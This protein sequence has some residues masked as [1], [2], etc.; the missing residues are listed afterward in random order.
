MKNQYFADARDLFKYDL[1]IS[2][3]SDYELAKNF[4][5]VPMLTPDVSTTH[6]SL[7][8]YKNGW[9]GTQRNDL[10]KFLSMCIK[11]KRRDI[12][13]IES[14][15]HRAKSCSGLS[16]KIYSKDN[17]FRNETRS[18][19]F[20]N[21]PVNLL[22]NSIIFLDPDTG[23]EIK[24]DTN[25]KE[26]HLKYVEVRNVYRKMDKNSILLIFQFIPRVRR[27]PYILKICER[28]DKAINK[29][30]AIHYVSDNKIVFFALSKSKAREKLL[31]RAIKGY[32][33]RYNLAFGG[34]TYHQRFNISSD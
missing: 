15:F 21:L 20:D 17:L 7:T 8:N 3:M 25:N 18:N 31:N 2:L 33:I 23:L 11:T 4:T 24:S 34:Q 26:A 16:V 28:L 29:K 30:F 14:F 10:V 32:S 6:G 19:Y 12:R 27:Q 1:I 9:P 5:F 22:K 13:N